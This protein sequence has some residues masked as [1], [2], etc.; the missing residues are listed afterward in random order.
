MV[1]PKERKKE[2]MKDMIEL[3][4][5]MQEAVRS[6][7]KKHFKGLEINNKWQLKGELETLRKAIEILDSKYVLDIIFILSREGEVLY[8]NEIKSNLSYINVGTLSK[9]LKESEKNGIIE[10]KIY[11]NERP[12]RVSYNLTKMGY[13]I[14]YL[15]LPMLVYITYFDEFN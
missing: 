11:P 3:I 15:L 8:F 12:I 1:Y 13:G 14:F 6:G 4:P 10:R 9:R 5:R 7:L 2:E